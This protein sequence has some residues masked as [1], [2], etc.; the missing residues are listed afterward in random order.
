MDLYE[1]KSIKP[2]LI[3]SMEEPFDS[4][5]Y[6]Y[7]LKFD[8]I[9]CIAYLDEQGIEL[10]NKRNM[11]LLPKFPE[12]KDIH[13]FVNT[14][15]IL[16]GELI[17]LKNGVPD[18]YK[19]Q[20]RTLLSDTFKMQLS[21]EKYPASYVAYDI[22]YLK[23][24]ATLKLPLLERK[25]LLEDV[26]QEDKKLA[27]SRYISEHGIQLYQIAKERNLE[28]VVAKVKD[29]QYYLDKRTKDWIK[30]KFLADKDFII[31]GYIP[32]ENG[33]I[34]LVLGQYRGKE[35]IYKGHVTLGVSN[36]F[37]SSN[38]CRII[39]SSPFMLTPAG[40]E[41]AIWLVPNLV[42]VVQ[43]MPNEK[44]I[45]RQPAFKGIRDD[46]LPEQCQE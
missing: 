42:G 43:Y 15:C 11:R 32:K 30:F 8:G 10:R 13:K 19:L 44:D 9:R 31:C 16:D 36:R 12:L 33:V 40:H 24:H 17:V 28:G 26:I 4:P 39:A 2:M 1:E 45:L 34:S 22:L 41:N 5:D 14:R 38:H 46:V 37:V 6:I 29:S 35:L 27:I 18:F 25:Q 3:K 7:E 23:D 20:Q 21:Y